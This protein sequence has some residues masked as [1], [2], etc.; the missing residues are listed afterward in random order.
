MFGK[1]NSLGSLLYN[2]KYH[3]TGELLTTT[4]KEHYIWKFFH[5]WYLLTLMLYIIINLLLSMCTYRYQSLLVS[6]TQYPNKAFLKEQI[7]QMQIHQL[8]YSQTTAINGFYNRPIAMS[9]IRREVNTCNETINFLHRK[10]IGKFHAEFRGINILHRVILT[11]VFKHEILKK[12]LQRGYK[13][14]LWACLKLFTCFIDKSTE[15]LCCNSCRRLHDLM[16]RNKTYKF[17]Y[18]KQIRS[19]RVGRHTS[20]Y[21]QIILKIF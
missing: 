20:L 14:W 13:P 2:S 18:I 8:R 9:L 19:N 11:I 12:T 10:C 15:S 16:S 4:I 7:R 21:L 17:L 1:T 5:L 6:L 3:R